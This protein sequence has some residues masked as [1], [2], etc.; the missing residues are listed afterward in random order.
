MYRT[1]SIAAGLWSNSGWALTGLVLTPS[2]AFRKPQRGRLGVDRHQG[3][4]LVL[5]QVRQKYR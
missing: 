5:I 4:T 1:I 3:P 2:L